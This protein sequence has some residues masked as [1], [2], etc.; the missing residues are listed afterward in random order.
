MSTEVADQVE[1]SINETCNDPIETQK[2]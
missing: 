2:V 1:I